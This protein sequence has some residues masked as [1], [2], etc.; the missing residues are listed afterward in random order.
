MLAKLTPHDHKTCNNDDDDNEQTNNK[1]VKIN[2]FGFAASLSLSHSLPAFILCWSEVSISCPC[3]PFIPH[4]LTVSPSISL[5]SACHGFPHFP[6]SRLWVIKQLRFMLWQCASGA[7]SIVSWIWTTLLYFMRIMANYNKNNNNKN[8]ER[9]NYSSTLVKRQSKML[10]VSGFWGAVSWL[11]HPTDV[12]V[13]ALPCPALGPVLSCSVLP[14]V[15]FLIFMLKLCQN[16]A[17]GHSG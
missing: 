17:R 3:M 7:V 9:E 1:N 12:C 6:V 15:V 8:R 2:L 10:V 4:I 11:C 13:V 14:E 16:C 5:S